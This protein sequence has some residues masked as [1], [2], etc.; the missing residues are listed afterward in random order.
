MS[1]N[2]TNNPTEGFTDT[3]DR[4]VNRRNILLGTSTLVAAAALTSGALAQAQKAAP[5]A[6]A[7]SPAPAPAAASGRRPNILVIFGDDVGQTNVSAY[8][9]GLMGYRT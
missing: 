1:D 5:A 2:K 8:S 3:N 7:A 4:A 9:F 6:P